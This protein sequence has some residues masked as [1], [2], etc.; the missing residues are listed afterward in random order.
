M[1]RNHLRLKYKN[2]VELKPIIVHEIALE[3]RPIE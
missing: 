3:L 2:I 1:K